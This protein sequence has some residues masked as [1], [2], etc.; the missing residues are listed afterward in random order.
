MSIQS[1]SSVSLER[2][3]D[4]DTPRLIVLSYATFHTVIQLRQCCKLLQTT[5]TKDRAVAFSLLNNLLQLTGRSMSCAELPYSFWNAV[6]LAS[7]LTT[8][9]TSMVAEPLHEEAEFNDPL[10]YHVFQLPSSECPNA[11]EPNYAYFGPL[12]GSSRTLVA[13]EHWPALG[14]VEA[15]PCIKPLASLPFSKLHVDSATGSSR[16]MP[17][18]TTYFEIS[19]HPTQCSSLPTSL[20]QEDGLEPC[21]CIGMAR[22]RFNLFKN[23]PGWTRHSF[24]F[25]GDD[26]MFHY[27]PENFPWLPIEGNVQI[28]AM[29]CCFGEGDT[30]GFGLVFNP[31]HRPQPLTGHGIPSKTD[32]DDED[33]EEQS[34]FAMF[35]TKQGV[36]QAVVL[37]LDAPCSFPWFPAVGIDFFAGV[38]VNL[39]NSKPFV[40]DIQRFERDPSFPFDATIFLTE[41]ESLFRAVMN[42]VHQRLDSFDELYQDNKPALPGHIFPLYS[43]PN[44]RCL[45]EYRFPDDMLLSKTEARESKGN[46]AFFWIKVYSF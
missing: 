12:N 46:L 17:S 10:A 24:G 7:R 1:A 6:A 4:V 30:V 16:L 28:G 21:V 20:P 43:D 25:H 19:I 42:A 34:N 18:C 33:K 32:D 44:L 26:G 23:M 11:S 2:V 22:P 38:E 36:L 39:G 15:G 8:W 9:P 29:D 13:D 35:F 27:D 5:I 45:H 3:L 14:F 31:A 41:E 40:F 37:G